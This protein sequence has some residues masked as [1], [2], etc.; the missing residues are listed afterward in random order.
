MKSCGAAGGFSGK[1]CELLKLGAQDNRNHTAAVITELASLS[2]V[3]ISRVNQGPC[4]VLCNMTR[5][6]RWEGWAGGS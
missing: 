5:D 1:F 2:P 6:S 4:R 3:I